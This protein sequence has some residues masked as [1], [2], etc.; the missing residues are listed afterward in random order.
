MNL[1]VLVSTMHQKNHDLLKIMNLQSDAI[2]VN[3]CD[4]NEFEEFEYQGHAIKF[5]SFN[6]RGVGLSRNNALMRA[7]ADIC[8]F[9]D[10]D[11]TYVDN[12]KNIITQ[13]FKDNPKAD[14]IVFNVPSLNLERPSPL[15]NRK[16]R[17]R[18]FNCLKY[19]AVTMAVKIEKI[20]KSN[21]YFSLLFGG[22][23]KYG[24]GEDSL[25]I[26]ECLRKK[27]KVYA[28]PAI[29]GY[30]SQEDSSWFNGYTDKFFMDKGAI[31]ASISQ[32]CAW[33]LCLQFVLRHRDMFK[34]DKTVINALKLLIEGVRGFQK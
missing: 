17:V 7:K 18:I 25:F 16:K 1:Q 19:G 32:R 11:V 9:A 5:L 12:Y 30:V 33:L 14:I 34:N 21:I 2:I 27:L 4:K 6:E 28:D 31:F 10:G 8:I 26:I 15:I 20:H 23:A 3:Q 22:G 29:I 24:S 13:A